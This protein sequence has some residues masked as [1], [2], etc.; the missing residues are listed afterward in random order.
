MRWKAQLTDNNYAG[1][2]NPL[3]HKFES[4]KCP[5]QHKQLIDFENGLLEL[6]KNVTFRK[7]YNNF[8]DQLDKDIKSVP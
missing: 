1:Y 5:P 3:F 6:V 8:H 4:K 7:V 2:A